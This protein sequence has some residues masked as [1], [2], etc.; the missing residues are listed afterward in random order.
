MNDTDFVA[1][2]AQRAIGFALVQAG[3]C[4]ICYYFGYIHGRVVG[5]AKHGCQMNHLRISE[6]ER[7]AEANW[8][9][10]RKG[11]G[12]ASGREKGES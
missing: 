8:E 11:L 10:I 5:K 3:I 12:K 7:I 6:D 4:M 2:I 9:L 1:I